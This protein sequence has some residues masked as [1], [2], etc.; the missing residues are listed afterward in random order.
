MAKYLQLG[1]AILVAIVVS[2]CQPAN[3]LSLSTPFAVI[4]VDIDI[5]GE[6]VGIE[7][8]KLHKWIECSLPSSFYEET[9][10]KYGV[11]N[12]FSEKSIVVIRQ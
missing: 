9:I 7:K 3:T 8:I 10:E 4:P 2:A 1:F 12:W 6:L 11:E 5:G